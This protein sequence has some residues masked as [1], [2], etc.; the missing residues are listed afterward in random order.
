MTCSVWNCAPCV[1]SSP[2]VLFSLFNSLHISV[3]Y[4]S[5][6]FLL[7]CS[8]GIYVPS[9]CI[10]MCNIEFDMRL[11]HIVCSYDSRCCWVFH[12][13]Y[14]DTLCISILVLHALITRYSFLSC[15]PMQFVPCTP[16]RSRW[17][18][19]KAG[20]CGLASPTIINDLTLPFSW[21]LFKLDED[22][23]CLNSLR[24]RDAYIRR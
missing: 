17:S 24:P 12:V 2:I 3:L 14:I 13:F 7:L 15:Y 19:S 16:K 10:F 18:G 4:S 1:I 23:S 8:L 11:K 22:L 5:D 9:F 21:V 20:S 6:V